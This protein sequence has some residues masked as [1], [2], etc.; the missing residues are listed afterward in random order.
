V[1]SQEV[2]NGQRNRHRDVTV[3]EARRLSNDHA[4]TN[5]LGSL[6][7]RADLRETVSGEQGSSAHGRN[8]MPSSFM[9]R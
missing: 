6:I 7:G 8:T 1:S 9:L 3:S 2:A 5:Q 4:A